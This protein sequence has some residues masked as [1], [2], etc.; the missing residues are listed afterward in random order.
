MRFDFE[1]ER[2]TFPHIFRKISI[3]SFLCILCAPHWE[4]AFSDNKI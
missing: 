4:F 2:D 3:V 1:N